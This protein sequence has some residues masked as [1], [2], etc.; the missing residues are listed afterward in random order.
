MNLPTNVEPPPP[1]PPLLP[2][3]IKLVPII[4]VF[5]IKAFEP[6]TLIFNS[7]L[8]PTPIF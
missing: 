1:I 2:L 5:D 3:T 4:P 7:L 6:L 8:T